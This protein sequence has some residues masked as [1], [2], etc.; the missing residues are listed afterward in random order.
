MS[1]KYLKFARNNLF[2]T[3]TC[4]EIS[5]SSRCRHKLLLRN[6]IVTLLFTLTLICNS[7]YAAL[8]GDT[9]RPYVDYEVVFDDNMLRT[10]DS[11]SSIARQQAFGS[12]KKSDISQ[13][14]T[15]GLIFEKTK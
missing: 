13:R 8:L 7:A 10:R 11:V 2:I 14:I 9:F 3:K 6:C 15:G 1:R 5:H 12:S 4:F